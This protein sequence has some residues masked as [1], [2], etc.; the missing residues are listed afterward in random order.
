MTLGEFHGIDW[1]AHGFVGF[2]VCAALVSPARSPEEPAGLARPPARVI[3]RMG[4]GS[5]EPRN[6]AT[7][8]PTA[9][10]GLWESARAF[11]EAPTAGE[12]R[13]NPRPN[14]TAQ[15]RRG[16]GIRAMMQFGAGFMLGSIGSM[17]ARDKPRGLESART[18]RDRCSKVQDPPVPRSI[19][20]ESMVLASGS[21]AHKPPNQNHTGGTHPWA[22]RM[23]VVGLSAS[24]VLALS[25]AAWAIASTRE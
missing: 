15:P 7:D 24:P 13:L 20:P 21:V 18:L 11:G 2:V 1:S 22:S 4:C 9:R 14:P 8:C 10:H 3:V 17:S 5:Y 19:K 16:R 23:S 6:G 25:S 12:D